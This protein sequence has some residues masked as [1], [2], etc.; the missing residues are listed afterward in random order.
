M[1]RPFKMQIFEADLCADMSRGL[2]SIGESKRRLL[3]HPGSPHHRPFLR[4]AFMGVAYQY[5]VLPFGL[6]LA[7]RTSFTKCT[8]TAFSPLKQM[9]NPHSELPQR[10]AGFSQIRMGTHC[11]RAAATQSP[12]L[13]LKIKTNSAKSCLPPRQRVVFLGTVI[14]SASV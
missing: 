11:S 1:R 6:S 10:L 3:S 8:D 12:L 13:G 14:N 2:V 9:G 5:I 4:F 7:P